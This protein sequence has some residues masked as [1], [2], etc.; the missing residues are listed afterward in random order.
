MQ[1]YIQAFENDQGRTLTQFIDYLDE[2]GRSNLYGERYFYDF[3]LI[4]HQ[5]SPV[6]NGEIEEEEE[7]QTILGDALTLLKD[8]I[9]IVEEKG[10]AI[11]TN[12]DRFSIQEM[13]M[14][15]EGEDDE[16]S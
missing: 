3:W 14:R 13:C 6:G 9:L 1:W 12:H 11:I 7:G 4:L 5:R 2:N 10:N 16:L 15:M 8:R